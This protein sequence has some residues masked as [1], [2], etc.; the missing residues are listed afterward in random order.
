VLPNTFIAGA[1][2]CG[3]TTLHY[4]L[5]KH[6]DI[7]F[8]Q[9]PQE[10]HF[11]DVE[12]NFRKGLEWYAGHFS[13]WNGQRIVAQTSPL[14]F[15]E[16][17][18]P[19]RI[20]EVVP[21]ARFILILRNPVDRAYSHY[22]H[23]VKHGA[24]KLSF[25]D[26]L[27]REHERIR[28]GFEG[29]RHFSYVSRGQYATQFLRY[30]EYFPRGNILA[31][32]FEDLTQNAGE[33]LRRCAEFLEVPLEG[34]SKVSRQQSFINSARMP[35]SRLVHSIGRKLGR[36]FPRLGSAVARLNLKPTRYPTMRSETRQSLQRRFK[37]DILRTSSLTG[38]DLS[39]WLS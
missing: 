31:L 1:Q 24:E 11:F 3:T 22:W 5:S 17:S 34:F 35:R 12:D 18:V 33:L 26:A 6:P 19:V 38:L 23:E 39:A 27:D 4:L 16:P 25:E 28:N 32:R 7:F 30:L 21:H 37:E 29:R 8:P 13:G 2:K 36:R 15:F 20:R 9:A 14:Y 10:I